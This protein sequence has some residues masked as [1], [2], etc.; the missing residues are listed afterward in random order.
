MTGC[1]RKS[2]M[3]KWVLKYGR[4]LLRESARR[5]E[6]LTLKSVTLS[7][8]A[9]CYRFEA[10]Q[11]SFDHRLEFDRKTMKLLREVELAHIQ[12][13]LVSLGLMMTPSFFKLADFR[14][15]RCEIGGLDEHLI[16]YFENHIQAALA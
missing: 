2:F 3:A 7:D 12:G 6:P 11:R 14:S 13:L 9:L 8:N 5:S 10:L 4:N 16:A 1:S 15:I